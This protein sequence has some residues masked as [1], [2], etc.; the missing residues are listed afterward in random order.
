MTEPDEEWPNPMRVSK[1]VHS[2]Y[3]KPRFRIS[4]TGFA[5]YK[6][7]S[8]LALSGVFLYLQVRCL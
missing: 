1:K 5:R 2:L 6:S 7:D 3:S 8:W 4:E